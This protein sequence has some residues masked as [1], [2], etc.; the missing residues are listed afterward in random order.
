M[1]KTRNPGR[2]RTSDAGRAEQLR[3]AKRRQRVRQRK[4]G[5]VHTQLDLPV[6]QAEKLRAARRDPTFADA[7]GAFLDQA[8]VDLRAWPALR[9]LAWNRRDRWIPAQE[10]L[11]LYERNWR[12][13]DERRLDPAEASLIERLRVRHG[14][15]A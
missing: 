1:E 9:D 14:A 11:A 3:L 4:A 15:G 12:F 2:P 7:L 8:V 10:A 6:E 5:I 13:V